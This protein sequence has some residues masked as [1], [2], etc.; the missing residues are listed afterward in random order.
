MR[1][2]LWPLANFALALP[3]LSCDVGTV[4]AK[5][6]AGPEDAAPDAPEEPAPV[7]AFPGAEGF[8]RFE[9]YLNSLVD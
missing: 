1:S 2:A 8:G 4:G 3:L 5:A 6:D 7:L 9:E